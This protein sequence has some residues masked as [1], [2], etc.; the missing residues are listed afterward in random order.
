[1]DCLVAKRRRSCGL[2]SRK[3]GSG[4]GSLENNLEYREIV[5]QIRV[6][7]QTDLPALAEEAGYR[8]PKTAG[9]RRWH[10]C[11][12][13]DSNPSA[14]GYPNGMYSFCCGRWSDAIDLEQL[15]RGGTF[16]DA[17]RRMAE[18]YGL[19]PT[20]ARNAQYP[21]ITSEVIAEAELFQIG[22]VWRIE[23][24]LEVVKRHLWTEE[25]HRDAENT[26]RRLT[27]HLAAVRAWSPYEAARIHALASGSETAR[28]SVSEGR[29]AYR[30]LAAAIAGVRLA[31]AA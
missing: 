29:E 14:Y 3:P 15:A 19:N 1:M 18:R 13:K 17:V 27:E 21:R 24:A 7:A 9:G 12:C 28:A 20:R 11:F 26:C 31:V 30:M 23:R 10:C 8:R 6:A 2:K 25:G 16:V 5:E 22:L 4:P